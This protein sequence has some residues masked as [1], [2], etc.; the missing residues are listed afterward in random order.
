MDGAA[1]AHGLIPVMQNIPHAVPEVT[2]NDGTNVPALGLG[3]WH[4]GEHRDRAV[5]EAAVLRMGLDLG[6]TLVDTAEMYGD[7][8]AERVVGDAIAADRDRVFVVSKVYPHNATAKGTIVACDRSL[9]RLRTDRID[10]YLLHWRGR[11]PLAETVDAFERLRAAGKIVRWGVSNFDVGDIDELLALPD[12]NRCAANQVL[13]NLSQRGVEFELR[14]RC[15][16]ND[17][18]IMAYS[19]F[20]QGDLLRNRKLAT[21][22]ASLGMTAA[23]LAIAWLLAQSGTIA[24]PQSSNVD[25]VREFRAAADVRLSPDALKMIDAAFPPPRSA[26][27]LAML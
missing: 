6:M 19:P 26:R 10:L 11:H 2:L 24:I 15:S 14:E 25:H 18:V 4:M 20:Q 7:G 13:Y 16:R 21:L 22:A 9:A 3:T 5:D 23:Q 17:I 8:G 12:G 1:R 27:P